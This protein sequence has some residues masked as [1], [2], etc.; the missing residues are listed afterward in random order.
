MQM[1]GA[2]MVF[3]CWGYIGIMEKKMETTKVS[4]G[5]H[6]GYNCVGMCGVYLEVRCTY[7]LLSNFSYKLIINPITQLP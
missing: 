1:A 6:W 2:S 4:W 3:I 5:I 7:N